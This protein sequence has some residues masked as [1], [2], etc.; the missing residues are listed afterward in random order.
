MNYN[1]M[2]KQL[3][4]EA[5]KKDGFHAAEE[6][7]EAVEGVYKLFIA[8]GKGNL[9]IG[10]AITDKELVNTGHNLNGYGEKYLGKPFIAS[11]N[12]NEIKD[13]VAKFETDMF[14]AR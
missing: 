7:A 14:T 12:V 2:V 5:N 10:P 11:N 3:F 1:E 9:E 13:F 8:C 4:A 6:A